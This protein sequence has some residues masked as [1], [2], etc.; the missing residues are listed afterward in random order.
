MTSWHTYPKIY[1][2]GHA[3]VFDILQDYSIIQEKVD[4]SQISFGVFKNSDLTTELK[5]KSKGANIDIDNPEKMFSVG[6]A[7]IK[8]LAQQNLLRIGYTY[9]CEYLQKPKHNVLAYDRIPKNHL[10]LFDINSGEET[11]TSALTI[12]AEANR[13]NI[14][15]VP[16]FTINSPFPLV[17]LDELLKKESF[18]GGQKIEGVVIKNYYRFGLDKKALMAK[19]VRPDFKEAH[20]KTWQEEKN[21]KNNYLS[22]LGQTYCTTPRWDKALI[23][24]KEQGKITGTP[25]DIALLVKE[26]PL[27][28]ESECKEEIKEQLYRAVHQ[29]LKRAWIKGL[30]E[31]YKE[32]LLKGE[33]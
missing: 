29:E 13:L 23:H 17:A 25:K 21:R 31:W 7:Y 14:D 11:Y 15:Y 27:D 12:E 26:V 32:K 33:V 6:V 5:I 4:G 28:I 2:L 16:S 8:E 24:L 9:R 20:Q 1:A 18:L 22:I 30:P 10:A 19:Y 3:A